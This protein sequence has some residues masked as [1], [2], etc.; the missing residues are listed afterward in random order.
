M[1][2]NKPITRPRR[3]ERGEQQ[4]QTN[5]EGRNGRTSR[6]RQTKKEMDERGTARP[7]SSSNSQLTSLRIA[8]REEELVRLICHPS[9]GLWRKEGERE[10]ERDW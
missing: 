4:H 9:S 7:S 6:Q 2:F 5:Y 3:A 10:R 8:L 1:K